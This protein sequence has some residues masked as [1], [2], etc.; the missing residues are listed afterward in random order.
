[1]RVLHCPLLACTTW[2]R[3]GKLNLIRQWWLTC[4]LLGLLAVLA[5]WSHAGY[6]QVTAAWGTLQ[7]PVPLLTLIPPA[8]AGTSAAANVTV[9]VTTTPT[10]P[11]VTAEPIPTVQAAKE[12]IEFTYYQTGTG[13]AVLDSDQPVEL[14]DRTLLGLAPQLQPQHYGLDTAVLAATEVIWLGENGA[15]PYVLYT[16]SLGHVVMVWNVAKGEVEH[17]Q[18]SIFHNSD[19]FATRILLV[20]DNSFLQQRHTWLELQEERGGALARAFYH[21]PLAF[22]TAYTRNLRQFG[23]WYSLG[24]EPERIWHTQQSLTGAERQDIEERAA[25]TLRTILN[26]LATGSTFTVKFPQ[27]QAVELNQNGLLVFLR[28]V[29][30][31]DYSLIPVTEEVFRYTPFYTIIAGPEAT[32]AITVHLDDQI[33]PRTGRSHFDSFVGGFLVKLFRELT[34]G[35]AAVSEVRPFPTLPVH[36]TTDSLVFTL[37]GEAIM[38]AYLNRVGT[39]WLQAGAVPHID[40]VNAS[41]PHCLLQENELRQA[42]E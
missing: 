3:E 34:A 39:S 10:V 5:Y 13:D 36:S 23:Q 32:L 26:N 24:G 15:Q 14:N 11:N 7:T 8:A 30:D 18:V 38:T 12:S 4:L 9:A 6:Q 35:G 33:D 22:N 40:H 21:Y 19:G 2:Y 27:E 16:N 29:Y 25:H 17:A 42:P 20:T 28:V 41:V 31:A 37:C 1:M